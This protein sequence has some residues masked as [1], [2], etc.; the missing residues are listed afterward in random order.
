MVTLPIELVI[1]NRV[2]KPQPRHS[3]IYQGRLPNNPSEQI[4]VYVPRSLGVSEKVEKV[5]LQFSDVR[6][7]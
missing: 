5:W 4:S 7:E 6:P 2:D 1:H 3:V